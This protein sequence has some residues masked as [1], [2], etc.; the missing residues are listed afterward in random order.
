MNKT[1]ILS[2]LALSVP[3]FRSKG[4]RQTGKH[5]ERKWKRKKRRRREGGE[6]GGVRL[7]TRPELKRS[8][9]VAI[10]KFAFIV[11][12]LSRRSAC[13]HAHATKHNERERGGGERE[14]V[15]E[16]G[17]NTLRASCTPE[18]RSHGPLESNP[19]QLPRATTATTVAATF[20]R[21]RRDAR[22]HGGASSRPTVSCP[23]WYETAKTRD[24]VSAPDDA[25]SSARGAHTTSLTLLTI[26]R[27]AFPAGFPK[28]SL[29]SLSLSP[30]IGNYISEITLPFIK[31][32]N[33]AAGFPRLL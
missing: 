10:D 24:L 14:K 22:S 15:E 11:R 5:E 31:V 12:L 20:C 1:L 3:R 30:L 7:R 21:R 18:S 9:H 2:E 13:V 4:R 19:K 25:C 23:G 32:I 16:D 6:E 8:R 26:N 33:I 17:R 28:C 27:L 29:L